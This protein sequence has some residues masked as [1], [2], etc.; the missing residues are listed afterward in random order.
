MADKPADT[1]RHDLGTVAEY[2]AG[3]RYYLYRTSEARLR[4]LD[5]G[6]GR[7]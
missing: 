7:S 5:D 3:I 2:L 1:Y 6:D 4:C